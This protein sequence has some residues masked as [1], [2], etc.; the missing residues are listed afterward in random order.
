MQESS[1]WR[2]AVELLDAGTADMVGLSAAIC[3][4]G[5]AAQW[6]T[7]AAVMAGA[8]PLDVVSYAALADA[9][10]RSGRHSALLLLLDDLAASSG[11]GK[12]PWPSDSWHF[13]ALIG[14]FGGSW[15]KNSCEDHVR[16]RVQP[17]WALANRSWSPG[18]QPVQRAARLA[19]SFAHLQ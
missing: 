11:L 12:R 7:G 13:M 18:Y 1:E 2:S 4:C 3:S 17:G 6:R 10:E 9:C 8:K 14:S 16:L 15:L 19:Q 5:R